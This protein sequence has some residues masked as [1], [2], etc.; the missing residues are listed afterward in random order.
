V[1][2]GALREQNPERVAVPRLE[3]REWTAVDRIDDLD[4][5]PP[6]IVVFGMAG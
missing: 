3:Q 5:A 1:V 4:R 2:A 6:R